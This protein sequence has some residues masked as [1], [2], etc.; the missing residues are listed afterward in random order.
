MDKEFQV[1]ALVHEQDKDGKWVTR[2]LP[3][4]YGDVIARRQALSRQLAEPENSDPTL[5]TFYAPRKEGKDNAPEA[6]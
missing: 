2:E 5:A 6:G 4:N 1:T 3:V